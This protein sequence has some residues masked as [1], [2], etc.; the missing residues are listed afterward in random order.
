MW[1]LENSLQEISFLFLPCGFQG[2]KLNSAD[3]V[4]SS[5]LTALTF[6]ETGSQINLADLKVAE[7]DLTP[8]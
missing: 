8:S 3:M 2:L 4:A 5:H 6:C 1:T 7:I